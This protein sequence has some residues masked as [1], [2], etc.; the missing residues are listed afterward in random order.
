[1][2]KEFDVEVVVNELQDLALQL[3]PGGT[4][5]KNL[6]S[7]SNT[8]KRERTIQFMEFL[9]EDIKR[10]V[11]SGG[12]IEENKILNEHFV[13]CFESVWRKVTITKKEEKIKYFKNILFRQMVEPDEFHSFLKLLSYVERL[14]EIQILML[15]NINKVFRETPPNYRSISLRK[16]YTSFDDA[17]IDNVEGEFNFNIIKEAEKT[18]AYQ[19]QLE[20]LYPTQLSK[21]ELDFY[22]LELKNFGFIRDL[23]EEARNRSKNPHAHDSS[24]PLWVPTKMGISLLDFIKEYGSSEE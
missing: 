17:G 5:A 15:Y 2:P 8:I 4:I 18:E 7:L 16:I 14:N 13:D 12:A 3:I 11:S 1:M 19:N 10:F 22:F 21:D 24:K 20:A 23:N 9:E 6:L